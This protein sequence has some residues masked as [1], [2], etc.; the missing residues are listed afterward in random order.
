MV[1]AFIMLATFWMSPN[2]KAESLLPD[3]NLDGHCIQQMAG[4]IQ[5]NCPTRMKVASLSFGDGSSQTTSSKFVQIVS[6]S[7]ATSFATTSTSNQATGLRVTITPSATTSRIWCV[8]TFPCRTSDIT[9]DVCLGTL[10]RDGT[11]LNPGGLG[12]A[13]FLSSSVAVASWNMPFAITYLDSPAST[14]AIV[15]EIYIRTS[16]GAATATFNNNAGQGNLV[17]AEIA[18]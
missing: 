14:S 2:A 9:Q 13:H 5:V 16:A 18:A 8:S 17:C 4:E 7:V 3:T 15:Y 10:A 6:S 1:G 12:M 11:D